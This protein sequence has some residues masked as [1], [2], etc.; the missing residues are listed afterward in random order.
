MLFRRLHSA[1][2]RIALIAASTAGLVGGGVLVAVSAYAAV[3]CRIDYAVTNQWQGGFGASVTINNRG[4]SRSTDGRSRGP[5]PAGQTITQVWK[6]EREPEQQQ[7]VTA[8]DVSYNAIDR[9]GCEHGVRVQRLLEQ[10]EQPGADLVHPQRHRCA[11]GS[12]APTTAAPTTVATPPTSAPPTTT[13]APPTSAPPTTGAAPSNAPPDQPGERVVQAD[14]GPEP[15]RRCSVR[16]GSNNFVSWRMLG[17]EPASVSYNLYRG[18]TKVN[19]S[20]ITNSTNYLDSGAAAGASYT[21]RAVINGVE[22]AASTPSLNL[23]QNFLDVP[24]STGRRH[25]AGRVAYTIRANDA[26]VGDLDG[27]GQ[28]EIVL[29]W[30]PTNSKDNSQSGYTGNVFVDAY[31]LNGQRLWRID[32]G[33][34]HPGRG[35]LHPVPG[36]RLLTAMGRAEVAMKTGDGTVSGTGQVIG[37]G[38]AGLPELVRLHPHR[39]RVPDHVQRAHRRGAVH[40]ELRAGARHGVVVGR[41]VR[42]TGWT[43]SSPG[44]RPGQP[45]PS[46][47]MSR[48]YYTRTVI[49]AWD[50]RNGSLTQRW[51]FDTNSAG[52]QY[53]DQGDHQLSVG[54]I[55]QG[56]AR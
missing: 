15:G 47:I 6:A 40:C 18:S 56:R 3:G 1:R 11:P 46:L 16:S 50:F 9:H 37:S 26:S 41:L 19:S 5:F 25:D 23:S 45:A 52:S 10:L 48:G 34:Q 29:K 35:A 13:G 36:V 55:D 49:A 27:D 39:S 2:L 8:T 33:P 21:V 7:Q 53:T 38:S 24:I 12:T 22:Q 17:W 4:R 30:D 54:D 51:V 43:G 20:P 44:R 42:A 32:L 31:R 28:Y 14:G